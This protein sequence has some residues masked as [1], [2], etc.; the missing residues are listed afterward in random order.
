[1]IE[2]INGYT[3]VGQPLGDL[4]HCSPFVLLVY[5]VSY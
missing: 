1:M 3:V 5:I 2:F 4:F